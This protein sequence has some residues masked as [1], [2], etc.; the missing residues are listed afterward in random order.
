MIGNRNIIFIKYYK[1]LFLVENYI[2]KKDAKIMGSC[3][4]R[5]YLL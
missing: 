1:I 5:S 2:K 4:R 3:N